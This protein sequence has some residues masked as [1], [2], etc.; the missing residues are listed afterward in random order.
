MYSSLKNY[1]DNTI[2]PLRDVIVERGYYTDQ[3]SPYRNGIGMDCLFQTF[4]EYDT[5]AMKKQRKKIYCNVYTP[6]KPYLFEFTPLA[7]VYPYDTDYK[8]VDTEDDPNKRYLDIFPSY[9]SLDDSTRAFFDK[10]VASLY[11]L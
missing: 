11:K 8:W 10:R 5:K 3:C 1:T 4:R 9:E 6:D 7:S 2:R